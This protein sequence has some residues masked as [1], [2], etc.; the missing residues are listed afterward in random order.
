MLAGRR[1]VL[2]I[3]GGVA[4]YKAAYIAR[5]L[6]EQGASV[7]VVMTPTATRFIGEATFAAL[8]GFDPIVNLFGGDDPSPHTTLASWADVI[9]VAPA[10]AATLAKLASGESS[11]ALVAT[12][13]ASTCPVVVAPAM[14]TEMWEHDATQENLTTLASRGYEIVRPESGE[15]AGGDVGIG[16]LADP[17]TIIETITRVVASGPLAGVHVIVTAGGTREA[18]DPVRFIGN[19]SSG[20]MG[21]AIARVAAAQGAS[22]TLVTAADDP[23][24]SGVVAVRVESAD[25]MAEAVW[26]RLDTCDVAVMAAAVA[27]FKPEKADTT[28]IK[29][30]SGLPSIQLVPTPD[31]LQG[32]HE[33]PNRPFLVGFAAETGTLEDAAAKAKRKGV[34]LLVANDVTSDGSGFGSDTN[35]VTFFYSDGTS[36]GLPLLD[37]D[38]VAKALWEEVHILRGAG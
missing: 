14:H 33:S 5:R 32:V 37:K 2:G 18:I 21:N 17:D 28:K 20:K 16:R 23:D 4:A 12:V 19:R 24:I 38:D 26:S 3:T 8:T 15:L 30:T 11:N 7:R 9:V 31:V 35:E 10:T 36:K 1:I 22:V 29:R 13:L 34:D 6:T 25:E 27:D